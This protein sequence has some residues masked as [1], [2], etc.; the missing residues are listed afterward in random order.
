MSSPL[1]GLRTSG[2]LAKY[3]FLWKQ[4]FPKENFAKPPNR[5]KQAKKMLTDE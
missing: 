4:S 2:D 5:C 1:R 3:P